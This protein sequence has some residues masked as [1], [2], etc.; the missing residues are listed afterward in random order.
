MRRQKIVE[1]FYLFLISLTPLLWLRGRE[2]IIG[3]DS[4]FFLDPVERLRTLYYAWNPIDEFGNNYSL[5]SGFLITLFPHAF[6]G[7]L[8]GSLAWAQRLAFIFWF[9]VMGI[10][11]YVFASYILPQKRNWP[12]RLIASTMYVYNFYILQAWFIA[13]RA[14][15][16]LYAALPLVLFFLFKTIRGEYKI[17]KGAFLCSLTL[18]FLNG[19]GVLPNYGFLVLSIVVFAAFFAVAAANKRDLIQIFRIVKTYAL[20]FLGFVFVNFYWIYPVFRRYL[21]SFG[22]EVAARGGIGSQIDWIIEISKNTSY[23]NLL[24]FQGIPDWYDNPA[25][26]FSNWYLNNPIAVFLSLIPPLSVLWIISKRIFSR[27]KSK[28]NR[29]IIYFA[30]ILMIVSMVFTA[31]AQPPFGGIYLFLIKHLPGFVMFR[32]PFYK[33]GGAFWF[34]YILIFSYFI[35]YLLSKKIFLKVRSYISFVIIA[36]ILLYHYPYFFSDIFRF[37]KKFTT[38]VE[39][40]AYVYK[41]N[42][43]VRANMDAEERTLLVPEVDPDSGIDAYSWGFYSFD[44]LPKSVFA[45][46][47]VG[48]RS[49]E[50]RNL[51]KA[52]AELRPELV[53]KYVEIYGIDKILW[54]GDVIYPTSGLTSSDFVD[55][56]EMISSLYTLE[57]QYGEW[58]LFDTDDKEDKIYLSNKLISSNADLSFVVENYPFSKNMSLLGISDYDPR[59]SSL[60][61]RPQCVACNFDFGF[62]INPQVFI[63]E[64]KYDTK[65]LFYPLFRWTEKRCVE[66]ASSFSSKIDALLV[67]MSKRVN[68][69]KRDG[70]SPRASKDYVS[71]LENIKV[72]FNSLDEKDKLFYASRIISFLDYHLLY[73]REA[74]QEPSLAPAI[75]NELEYFKEFSWS[76]DSPSK[77]KMA[78]EN[79]R[80]EIYEVANSS[81]LNM[82]IDGEE[83]AKKSI[84]I[85]AGLRKILIE[86]E[87]G[88][89]MAGQQEASGHSAVVYERQIEN[90]IPKGSYLV[91]FEYKIDSDALVLFRIDDYI[92]NAE[93]ILFADGRWHKFS[94]LFSVEKEKANFKIYSKGIK[95]EFDFEVR[96]YFIGEFNVPNIYFYK[97]IGSFIN[98]QKVSYK[99]I[100][101]IEYR[102]SL[103]GNPPYFLVLDE[104]YEP[105]WELLGAPGARHVKVNG[106]TNGWLITDKPTGDLTIYYNQQRN[107]RIGLLISAIGIFSIILFLAANHYVSR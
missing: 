5:Y 58:M 98:N 27:I 97:D 77:I 82:F 23:L 52:I 49:T 11:M 54:R 55:Q 19:G 87:I 35:S 45:R 53:E 16:S 22:N 3:H 24:R 28:R 62:R 88:E 73:L 91:S 106:Y 66:K 69:I 72:Y 4:G 85:K 84:N 63:P 107:F 43:Y 8:T 93:F 64:I 71:D 105:F 50:S 90:L 78:F 40:P 42:D 15:F 25:H 44:Y 104:G 18:F 80:N 17:L 7:Y 30:S 96:N 47:V 21:F 95:P 99:R 79:P 70:E 51:Y 75:E 67:N 86:R 39:I 34:S 46:S 56:K 29:K 92:K 37:D 83:V 33:F 76:S 103:E 6:F 10:S 57:A 41:M 26:P 59:Y 102:I 38:R 60:I 74:G 61:L 89:N 2:V 9:F 94:H 36:L 65:S 13:E 20:F 81:G 68:E 48:G 14:K 31:G 101:P 1:I 32:N 100:S 12:F